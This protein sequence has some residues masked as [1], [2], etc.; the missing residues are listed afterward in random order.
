MSNETPPPP[1]G[2]A[3]LGG[4]KHHV[5]PERILTEPRTEG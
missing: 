3:S 1:I 5:D 4:P 2:F